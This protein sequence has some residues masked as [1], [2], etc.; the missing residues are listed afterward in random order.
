MFDGSMLIYYPLFPFPG[1]IYG[2]ILD[3]STHTT[4]NDIVNMLDASNLSPEKIK[5]E[6]NRGYLPLSM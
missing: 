2:R 4:K 3:I 1:P 6:Y 5:V